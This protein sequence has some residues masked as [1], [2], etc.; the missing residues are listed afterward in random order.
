VGA[1]LGALLAACRLGGGWFIGSGDC[2]AVEVLSS[3]LPLAVA[4]LLLRRS[5]FSW[6]RAVAG[7]AAAGGVGVV[8]LELSCPNATVGHVVSAHLFPWAVTCALALGVRRRL[9]SA[10]FAP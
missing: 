9:R 8:L 10:S 5:A 6:S 1:A 4:V 7:V 2:P 3:V